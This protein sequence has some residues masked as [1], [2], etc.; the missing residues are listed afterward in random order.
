MIYGNLFAVET[1]AKVKTA[2]KIIV[3]K[4]DGDSGTE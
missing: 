4:H 3:T 1:E 2:I